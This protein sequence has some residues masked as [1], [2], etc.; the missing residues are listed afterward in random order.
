MMFAHLTIA[1]AAEAIVTGGIVA[2]LQRSNPG[3]LEATVQAEPM[4]RCA[5]RRRRLARHALRCGPASGR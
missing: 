5:V 2:Y 3:L 4:R 1:G